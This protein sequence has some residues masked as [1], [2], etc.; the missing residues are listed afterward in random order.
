[1]FVHLEGFT[2]SKLKTELETMTE[3]EITTLLKAIFKHYESEG[4]LR[5]LIQALTSEDPREY[6][7]KLTNVGNFQLAKFGV[8]QVVG[9]SIQKQ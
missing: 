9:E 1:M 8:L 3:D 4:K 7:L 6:L 5:K 2:L